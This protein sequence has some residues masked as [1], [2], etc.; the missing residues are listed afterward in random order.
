MQAWRESRCFT[1][2]RHQASAETV[3]G[4]VQANHPR[5]DCQPIQR[6]TLTDYLCRMCDGGASKHVRVGSSQRHGFWLRQW[7]SWFWLGFEKWPAANGHSMT[8]S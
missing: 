8:T 4:R 6:I 1:A 5:L 2:S 3:A 7:D